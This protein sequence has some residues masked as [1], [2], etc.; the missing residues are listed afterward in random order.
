MNSARTQDDLNARTAWLILALI[1]G[2]AVMLR[3]PALHWLS[4]A[5][6]SAEYSFHPDVNRFVL[7]AQDM[8]AP[9]PDGY[10]QGMTTQLYLVH[11]LVKRFA[12]VGFLQILQAIT[13]FYSGLLVL[14]TYVTAR[15]WKM[16]R[17]RALLGAAFF[18][19]A[20]LAVVQSNFGTAD[21]TAV[22]LFYATLLAGGQYLRTHKQ[23]WFVV[24]CALSGMA[25]AVKFFVP[26]F[27]PLALVLA[28]QRRGERLA[29]GLA[30]VFIVAGSFETLSFFN[31]TP[32]DLHKLYWMLR[33]DNVFVSGSE[34]GPTQ[35]PINQL[36]LYSWDLIS[37]VGIPVAFLFLIGI[38]R[39]SQSLRMLA[40]RMIKPLFAGGWQS[41]IT[42]A[43][44][45]IASLSVHALLI[46]IAG[47]HFQRHL[48]VFLPAI[49]IAAS[50]TLYGLPG[51]GKLTAT[52]RILAIA[53]ALAYMTYEAYSIE[54]LY[55]ADVRNDLANWARQRTAEGKHVISLEDY[56]EVSG[57]T[58][59]PNYNPLLLD[60]SSFIVTCD[61][62][63]VRYLGQTKASEIFHAM[64]GQN[65]V[66]FF[67]GIFAGRSSEFGIVREFTS[68]PRGLE[69][70]LIDAK[71]LP[72]LGSYVP[73]RCYALGRADVLPPDAQRA[74]RAEV[75]GSKAGW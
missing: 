49:C 13:I 23:L 21:V 22:C 12:Q 61:L 32:W 37:A 14:L 63:Y 52:A 24:L 16:N 33:D 26:L 70:R 11:L 17:G 59:S 48:L 42:P 27:V 18:S 51:V 64:V 55:S 35:G 68:K 5:G 44:L 62:E 34:T 2:G 54:G 71:I 19:V 69:L 9:N 50:Q 31:Y 6:V 56:L 25:V 45:F 39:W 66:V 65:G 43:S 60:W 30:A 57:S 3:I 74:I 1:I 72:P 15:F 8:S 58:F 4:G 73:R 67:N 75:A 10:P 36:R 40:F 46:L 38:V 20:P 28:V 29:Q 53:V 41:L 47:V 7:A